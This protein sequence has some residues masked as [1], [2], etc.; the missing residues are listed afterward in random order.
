MLSEL[1]RDGCAELIAAARAAGALVLI[2]DGERASTILQGERSSSC[3]V[4]ALA[5]TV[6]DLGAGDVFAAAL[7]VSLNE[8]APVRA[9]VRFA[10]AA[11]AVRMA[12][13]GA[14]CDRRSRSDRSAAASGGA[15]KATRKLQRRCVRLN[16]RAERCRHRALRQRARA[17]EQQAAAHGAIST[18]S[19]L[20]KRGDRVDRVA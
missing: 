13:R 12:A 1:E 6:E 11:A 4:P 16:R 3:A 7:F 9:A 20:R 5:H 14:S 18:A 15:A 2:T 17:R 8:G 10:T 19:T